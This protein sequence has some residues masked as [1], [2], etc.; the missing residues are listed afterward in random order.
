ML[1]RATQP[2]RS[3]L[4]HLLARQDGIA[5]QLGIFQ[6]IRHWL[7]AIAVL[8]GSYYLRQDF[9]VLVIAGPDHHRVQ[10][11]IGQ[12]LLGILKGLGTLPEKPLCVRGSALA[13]HRPEVT[14]AAQIEMRVGFSGH[15]EHLPVARRSVAAADLADLDPVIGPDNPRVRSG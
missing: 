12:H 14:D 2:L 6:G 5:G 4:R 7:F 10:F 3:H 1:I 11:R 8:A 15:L 13:I 9:R